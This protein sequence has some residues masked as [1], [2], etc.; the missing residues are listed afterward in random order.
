MSE[1]ITPTVYDKTALGGTKDLPRIHIPTWF[2]MKEESY[3]TDA[4]LNLDLI[5]NNSFSATENGSIYSDTLIDLG[6]ANTISDSTN[7][8]YKDVVTIGNTPPR[9]GSIIAY[10]NEQET[11]LDG[12]MSAHVLYFEHAALKSFNFVVPHNHV[13]KRIKK[14]YRFEKET[15]ISNLDTTYDMPDLTSKMMIINTSE[16][17]ATVE[18]GTTVLTLVEGS[19]YV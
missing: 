12:T 7:N 18:S 1:T 14:L 11:Y 8:T 2:A 10:S 17:S 4:L 16:S 13:I 5:S 6:G 15:T 9:Q 19:I 3:Y